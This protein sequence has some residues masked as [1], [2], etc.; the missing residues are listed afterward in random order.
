M[1]KNSSKPRLSLE[2]LRTVR[3]GGCFFVEIT[4]AILF[5]KVP[6]AGTIHLQLNGV[7]HSTIEISDRE[8]VRFEYLVAGEHTVR[9]TAVVEK[10]GSGD[11]IT[12][13]T[14]RSFTLVPP[15]LKLD[16]STPTKVGNSWQV[17][18]AA[19]A[20]V[21]GKN[22]A[23]EGEVVEFFLNN[24][25]MASI[26]TNDAGIATFDLRN[27]SEGQHVIAARLPSTG[28]KRETTIQVGEKPSGPKRIVYSKIPKSGS[29]GTTILRITVLNEKGVGV[30]SR[31]VRIEDPTLPCGG[32]EYT[33]DSNGEVVHEGSVGQ[34][35][36]QRGITITVP[37]TDIRET[38]TL[39]WQTE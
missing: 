3:S 35:E 12:L 39:R 14:T 36:K 2:N 6:G 30:K 33:T 8:V 37:G 22:I 25:P 19:T 9:A 20:S 10:D 26:S 4:T 27:L 1:A 15:D 13:T 34:N 38:L 29:M 5:G 21:P 7:D 11:L 28:Q 17:V 32:V 31:I 24:A 23:A 18:V 16:V